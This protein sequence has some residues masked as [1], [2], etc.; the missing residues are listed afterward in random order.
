MDPSKVAIQSPP[1]CDARAEVMTANARMRVWLGI[2]LLLLL[3]CEGNVPPTPAARRR[4]PAPRLAKVRE[5]GWSSSKGYADGY[6]QARQEGRPMLVFFTASWCHFCHQ[7]EAEAF[8]DGQ[9]TASPGNSP[10][11]WSMRTGSRTFARSSAF[12]A[13]PQSSFSPPRACR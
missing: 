2:V 9:V 4:R 13:T 1:Q 8:N 5:A 7:M 11:S 6:R 3:G 10:A 12:A